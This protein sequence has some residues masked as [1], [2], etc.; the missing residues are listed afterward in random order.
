[1]FNSIIIFKCS[2]IT[3]RVEEGGLP[4][5]QE[6]QNNK[7]VKG[8]ALLFTHFMASFWN[9]NIKTY[10]YPLKGYGAVSYTVVWASLFT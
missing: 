3:Q 10:M 9:K 8:A 6:H 7:R 4:W 2:P 1:M 5:V